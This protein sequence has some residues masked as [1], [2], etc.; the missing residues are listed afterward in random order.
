MDLT[1]KILASR[2]R[3]RFV[4]ITKR[5]QIVTALVFVNL[6]EVNLVANRL[7]DKAL[8]VFAVRVLNDL[9][10]YVALA[11]DSSDNSCLTHGPAT[12]IEPFVC[13]F[14]LFLTP[15][16]VSSTSTIPISLGSPSSASPAPSR[17]HINHA[18]R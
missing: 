3:N 16:K 2:V 7:T 13:V 4:R 9:A 17:W 10:D 18:M 11:C 15:M 12:A 14:V 6:D 5:I 1:A 8:D